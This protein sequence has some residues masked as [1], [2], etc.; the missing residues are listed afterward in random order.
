MMAMRLMPSVP[1]SAARVR[2]TR[3]A[4]CCAAWIARG[5]NS[6]ARKVW[7]Q[8]N[9]PLASS[10]ASRKKVRQNRLS[11]TNFF[12][13]RGALRRPQ[14][15]GEGRRREPRSLL[16]AGRHALE[17]ELRKALMPAPSGTKT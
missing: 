12:A 2:L 9:T 11:A 7:T 5:S 8:A 15:L 13:R 6:S 17:A 14:P 3:L 1:S 4:I 16:D 10:S